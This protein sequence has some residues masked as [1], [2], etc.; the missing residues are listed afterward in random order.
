[1]PQSRTPVALRRLV[2]SPT[3]LPL[4]SLGLQPARRRRIAQTGAAGRRGRALLTTKFLG[5]PVEFTQTLHLG[6]GRRGL[7]LGAKVAPGDAGRPAEELLCGA[8][9]TAAPSTLKALR[10]RSTRQGTRKSRRTHA[11]TRARGD[12]CAQSHDRA[13]RPAEVRGSPGRRGSSG[14]APWLSRRRPWG[15][16]EGGLR[17]RGPGRAKGVSAGA[18]GPRVSAAGSRPRRRSHLARRPRFAAE[19]PGRGSPEPA[20]YFGG[21]LRARRNTGAAEVNPRWETPPAGH[22]VRIE[23]CEL[24]GAPCTHPEPSL[25]S[26]PSRETWSLRFHALTST[27]ACTAP[28]DMRSMASQWGAARGFRNG[29]VTAHGAW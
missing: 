3:Y 2:R 8:K 20:G 4:K 25:A 12:G 29:R 7:S 22:V 21:A 14:R 9:A 24:D 27:A 18:P 17:A 19:N 26:F 10:D 13:A 28:F 6:G 1:M 16:P 23:Q 15:G 11:Q 5:T